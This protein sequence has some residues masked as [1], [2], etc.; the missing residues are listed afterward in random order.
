MNFHV[1]TTKE[2]CDLVSET[3]DLSVIFIDPNW[4]I[5]HE[6][7]TNRALNPLYVNNKQ[8]FFNPLQFNATNQFDYPVITK[9]AF[10]EKFIICS[11]YTN[12]S[13]EGTVLVGPSLPN[14]ISDKVI[15]GLV[16]DSRSFFSRKE[17]FDY[18]KS[19]PI[20]E[21][22][23]L[24]SISTIIFQMFNHI[25]LSPKTVE[26][27]NKIQLDLSDKIDKNE[28]AIS[29]N[30]QSNRFHDR[31]FEKTMLE[32]VKEGRVDE[33]KNL[34]QKEEEE[35]SILSKSSYLRSFKNHIITL[36]T[37]ASRASI[38]GGVHD[39]IAFGLHD[40]FILQ[41]EELDR[42]DEIRL[43]AKEILY[44]FAEKVREAQNDRYSKTITICRDYIYRHLYEDITHDDIANEVKL[45]PK[46]LSAL[47][48]KEVGITVSEYI[49]LT[50]INE[51]KKLLANSKT[52]ISEICTLLS[53]ND[54]SYFTKVFK[55]V[56]G[57]T[58][59]LYRE[60]HHL[61]DS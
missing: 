23:K 61:L 45:S 18:Y 12:R 10:S 6:S 33:I 58:P 49:Q 56:A 2:I 28:L 32:I 26:E 53:F 42:L 47:F 34:P 19:I 30:L 4:K 51:A 15:S 37:L 25:F 21:T 5:V 57:V 46:Y 1:E 41:V 52:P 29:E 50:K 38:E 3:F 54:Q 24:I 60:K 8:R 39:E 59:K 31:I 44:T 14:P 55:K 27:K 9:S 11:I 35:S 13:F 22:K 43:L 48:K 20:I 40:R 17:V 16:H 36:I 7:L